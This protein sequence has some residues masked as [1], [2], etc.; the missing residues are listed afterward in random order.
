MNGL[1]VAKKMGAEWSIRNIRPFFQA[2]QG[3]L[4]VGFNSIR[5]FQSSRFLET[6][7]FNDK[8]F[9]GQNEHTPDYYSTLGIHRSADLDTIKRAY[10]NLAKKFHPDTNKSREARFMFEFVAEAYDVLSDSE[11]RRNYDTHGFAKTFG[12]TTSYGPHR[13]TGHQTRDSE[14]LFMKIFGESS[15]LFYE[16]KLTF[17]PTLKLLNHYVQ[18][19]FIEY[20]V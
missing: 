9:N 7:A 13:P 15:K 3:L 18:C 16:N 6:T 2:Y 1:Y 10:Y 12:G 5:G 17:E 14:E 11:K 19:F 8:D 20:L 4:L